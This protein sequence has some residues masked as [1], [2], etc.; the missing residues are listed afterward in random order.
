MF[1]HAITQRVDVCIRVIDFWG[2]NSS[3]GASVRGTGTIWYL[4]TSESNLRETQKVEYKTYFESTHVP[5]W[6]EHRWCASLMKKMTVMPVVGFVHR[7][8]KDSKQTFNFA[9]VW[10]TLARFRQ[11]STRRFRLLALLALNLRQRM[12][13]LRYF[14]SFSHVMRTAVIVAPRN[15]NNVLSGTVGRVRSI[16]T[17]LK[18]WPT[19]GERACQW[20]PL[21]SAGHRMLGFRPMSFLW[22]SRLPNRNHYDPSDGQDEAA[23]SAILEKVMKGR[24]PTDLM[25]RC[26]LSSSMCH[27]V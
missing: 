27:V 4:S 6:R 10:E 12:L 3:Y 8:A 11:V 9:S 2:C 16:Y 25:L 18:Q 7:S 24:Q 19:K 20:H 26:A 23:R 17:G 14:R 21:R 13:Q 5:L 1:R 15:T 22:N